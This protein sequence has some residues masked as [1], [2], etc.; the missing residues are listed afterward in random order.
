MDKPINEVRLINMAEFASR[1]CLGPGSVTKAEDAALR[2]ITQPVYGSLEWRTALGIVESMMNAAWEN[3]EIAKR[4]SAFEVEYW[5][6][7]YDALVDCRA[8][9]K[10]R[11]EP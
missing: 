1:V 11:G 10:E 3:L 5:Q 8:A 6:G 2:D 7:R 4:A 9:M